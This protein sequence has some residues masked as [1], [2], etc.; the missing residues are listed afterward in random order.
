MGFL[1]LYDSIGIQKYIY[2][3]NHLKDNRGGSMLVE[4]CFDEN[5]IAAV[6]EA[7]ENACCDWR[8]RETPAFLK[9]DSVDCEVIYIGGGNA[10]V[11]FKTPELY[12]KVNTEFSRRL[13][14]KMPGVTVVS[15]TI[16]LEMDTEYGKAVDELFKKIQLKKQRSRGLMAAPCLSVTRECSYTRKPA[17]ALEEDGKWISEEIEKKR[18]KV[19]ER[20]EEEAYKETDMMAG[21]QG[22]QWIATVHI[23]GNNMGAHIQEILKGLELK[24]GIAAMRRFSKGIQKIYVDAYE[25]MLAECK[26]LIQKSK[27]GRLEDYKEKPPFRRIYGAGDDLTFVCYGPLAIKAAELFMRKVAAHIIADVQLSSCAGI[28][29][30][31]PG[32]PFFKAYMIA[33][34]CCREAKRKARK[35]QQGEESMGSYIDF[36]IVRGSQNALTALRKEDYLREDYDLLLRPYAVWIQKKEPTDFKKEDLEFF[37]QVS[38]FVAAKNI[39]A[40]KKIARSKMKD[41]RNAYYKGR[42]NAEASVALIRRRNEEELKELEALLRAYRADSKSPY[43]VDK[44]AVLFDAL[45]M[46]DMYIPL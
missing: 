12:R 35:H 18:A 23:D 7:A 44:K 17:A 11:Y 29:Y 21:K 15:E 24:D 40:K 5:L 3:S 16:D 8:E 9:E 36:Q 31:K 27:D 32:Y 39:D 34:Q 1:A 45:E 20:N 46:M 4:E 2:I 26:S 42:K 25:E 38:N 41:L 43:I 13:L 19:K 37:Y 10:Q 30:S 6:K 14:E 33:E 22:E 28:A